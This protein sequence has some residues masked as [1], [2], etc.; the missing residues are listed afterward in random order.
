MDETQLYTN[1]FGIN[2]SQERK[3]E[4]DHAQKK[5]RS[6]LLLLLSSWTGDGTP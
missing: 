3:T 4:A 2:E 6:P 5:H 1:I